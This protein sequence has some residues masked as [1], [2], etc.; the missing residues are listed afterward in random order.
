MRL[1]RKGTEQGGIFLKCRD[2]T[3]RRFCSKHSLCLNGTCLRGNCI[4]KEKLQDGLHVTKWNEVTGNNQCF[5]HDPNVKFSLR[6]KIKET[7]WFY[8]QIFGVYTLIDY[9]CRLYICIYIHMCVSI[10]RILYIHIYKVF[11]SSMRQLIWKLRYLGE[12]LKHRIKFPD[13]FF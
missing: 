4:R 2:T 12:F 11:F 13:I 6:S 9:I 3:G 5:P 1:I 7:H 10:Y 8:H